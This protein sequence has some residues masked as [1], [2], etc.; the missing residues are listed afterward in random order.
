MNRVTMAALA[1]MLFVLAG[2]IEFVAGWA[3]HGLRGMQILGILFFFVGGL[4]LV[5]A[6]RWSR[7]SSSK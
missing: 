6:S 3:G 5:I 1:G 7:A 2:L 4:W